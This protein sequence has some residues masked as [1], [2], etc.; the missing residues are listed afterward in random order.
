MKVLYVS[1]ASIVPAYRD[2]LHALAMHVDLD[3]L[4]PMRWN[5]DRLDPADN[6]GAARVH[7]VRAVLHGH[8]H[9]HLLRGAPGLLRDK[10]PDLVH[11]DEEPYSAVT[12]QLARLCRR[13]RVPFL[14]FAWQNLH[15]RLPPPFGAMRDRVFASAAAAIAGTA[16]AAEVLRRAGWTGE[17][18]VIPQLG[19]CATRFRPDATARAALRD[20]LGIP[21]DAFTAG[22]AGRLVP[23]KGV[24]LLIRA[25]ATRDMH[26]LIVGDG[27]E[28]RRLLEFSA[29]CGSLAS[30]HFVGHVSSLEMPR[31]LNAMDALVLPSRGTAGWTEQFGRVLVEAM[32]CG[33]PVIGAESGEIPLVIGG[34]GMTFVEG[35][36]AALGARLAALRDAPELRSR[37]AEAGRARVLEL[38][39]HD[40]VAEQ[41]V[42]LYGSTVRQE[43]GVCPT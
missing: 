32:S 13:Q 7:G 15:K 21:E 1:K 14:F 24:D 28:R 25:A 22:F 27:A 33:V 5:E 2:K 36:D 43:S 6:A 29:S 12:F 16:R 35:D 9:L 42:E 26:V 40:R 17:T 41:T 18:A 34:A 39:T 8:N 31:W 11:I 20:R 23:E 30:T 10:A 38:F 19:V 3:A 4:V 37:L